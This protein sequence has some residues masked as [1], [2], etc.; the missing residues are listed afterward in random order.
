MSLWQRNVLLLVGVAVLAAAPL[1]FLRNVQ[2]A[3]ADDRSTQAI[4]ELDRSYRPWFTSPL[5]PGDLESVLFGVQAFV[6]SALLFG[7]AGALLARS[8]AMSRVES[9]RRWMMAI[10]GVAAVVFVTLLFV[11]TEFGEIQSF[12]NAVQGACLGTFAFFLGHWLGAPRPARRTP[13]GS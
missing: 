5:D 4:Q 11:R 12:R 3:G 2:W 9:V 7:F 13:S 10:S 1:L 8:R 6:G